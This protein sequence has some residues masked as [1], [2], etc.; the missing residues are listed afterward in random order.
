MVCFGRCLDLGKGHRRLAV[1][2]WQLL[3]GICPSAPPS[4]PRRWVSLMSL[5]LVDGV[6]TPQPVAAATR[7]LLCRVVTYSPAMPLLL[8]GSGSAPQQEHRSLWCA[9][10]CRTAAL[11][12]LEP[13]KAHCEGLPTNPAPPMF[14]GLGA[15]ENRFWDDL[16]AEVVLG[17]TGRVG[18][19]IA[20][21][22]A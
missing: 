8:G 12:G 5:I 21:F 18:I 19:A 16:R 7:L 17:H 15:Q 22:R 11:W 20:Y 13:P 3:A 2:E 9:H 6:T 4:P 1:Q 10:S 14:F